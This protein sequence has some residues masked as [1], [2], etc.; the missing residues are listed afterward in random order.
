M[1]TQIRKFDPYIMISVLFLTAFAVLTMLS[2]A[3]GYRGLEYFI[4]IAAG[5][6]IFVLIQFVPVKLHFASAYILF[7]FNIIMI[8]IFIVLQR[9]TYT[10]YME[11]ATEFLKI[12]YI[13]ALSRFIVNRKEYIN[14]LRVYAPII[15]VTA[16]LCFI[17]FYIGNP[18]D[19]VLLYTAMMLIFY[20]CDMKI[21]NMMIALI[22][23]ISFLIYGFPVAWVVYIIITSIILFMLRS[24]IAKIVIAVFISIISGILSMPIWQLITS[25][26]GGMEEYFKSHTVNLHGYGWNLLQ[27]TIATGSGGFFG[28]GF[29]KGTQKG[30]DMIQ[31][32]NNIYIF[33]VI[34]EE[35][36]FIGY[37]LLVIAMLIILSRIIIL[38]R[39][40]RIIY[41]RFIAL[42]I[43][44]VLFIQFI[45]NISNS[46]G[47]IQLWDCSMPL[48]SLNPPLILV[49]MTGMG[50]VNKICVERF[51]YW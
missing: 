12:T 33:S 39:Q 25:F 35:L 10:L 47:I 22:P 36:G 28:K 45:L 46:I 21:E 7:V 23:S 50:I 5:F 26:N 11:F 42:S 27:S 44:T 40:V 32:Q 9:Y 29:F 43:I 30:L 19:A 24:G 6:L 15:L 41:S 17:S 1:L 20:I 3:G 4:W 16:L 2:L 34:G 49:F 38:F 13:L 51:E 37:V 18:A 8:L 48:F 31:G 14:S